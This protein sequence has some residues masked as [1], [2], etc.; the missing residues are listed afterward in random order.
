MNDYVI[1]WDI[2]TIPDLKG[3]AAANFML[4]KSD[5]EIREAMGDKFP[6]HI[7]HS[8]VSIGA[9]IARRESEYWAIE[10]LGAPHVGDRTEKELIQAFVNKIAE[11]KPQLVTFNGNSF[12]LPVLRY[13]AMS[14][15]ISAPGLAARPYFNRYTEDSIDLCDVLSSFAPQAKVSLHGLCRM[16]GLPGKPEHIDGGE[17]ER[18]Y[19]QGKIKEIADYCET[20]IVNTY[21]LWLRH[22][23]FRGRLSPTQLQLSE[24]N[25]TSFIAGR[26]DAKPHLIDASPESGAAVKWFSD[27]SVCPICAGPGRGSTRY[28]GALCQR[29]EALVVDVTGNPVQLSNE[30]FSGGL[31]IVTREGTVKSR[32]AEKLPLYVNEI[33]CRAGEHHL[34]GVVIQPVQVWKATA[35][36]GI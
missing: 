20:D 5:A 31:M 29:C 32:E 11:L 36:G 15:S 12:D 27:G 22:E 35:E 4:D 21:R 8:I 23:L 16:M 13:R 14:H 30:G 6:K 1:V 3:F 26:A 2:E 25:L 34:G 7:Y 18:Y 33:A 17:V 28:P 24:K 19:L 9:L 10:A